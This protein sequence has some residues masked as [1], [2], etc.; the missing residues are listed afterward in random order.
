MFRHLPSR[1]LRSYMYVPENEL[2]T[3]AGYRPR[4]GLN[5][6][7]KASLSLKFVEGFIVNIF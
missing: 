1:A 5:P 7:G 3:S 4:V 2:K 6:F